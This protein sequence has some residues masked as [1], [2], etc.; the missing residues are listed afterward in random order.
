MAAK[1]IVQTLLLAFC[2]AACATRPMSD[3]GAFAQQSDS[4]SFEP[5]EGAVDAAAL[6][7]PVVHD[8]QLTGAAC[9][10]HA[11]A[12]VVNYWRGAGTVAGV[13]IFSASPP[14]D[15]ERGY[16][17]AEIAVLAGQR[18]LVASGVRLNLPDLIS[19]LESGR[20]VL[21]PVRIPSIYVQDRGLPRADARVVDLARG[22]VMDRVGRVSEMT[23]LALV[24]HYLL[25][26]GYD[27]DRFVVVEP[28]MGYRTISFERLA[29]YRR[30]FNDA[31]IV[32]SAASAPAQAQPRR[33]S[34][35]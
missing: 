30:A 5:F 33:G 35:R 2:L 18:G 10:A 19:E 15:L 25:L 14:A 11:L 8:R 7:L 17:I 12:S 20:P 16:S 3:V 21:V 32:F 26:V 27:R 28:V 22:V 29:R 6:V 13:D 1:P 9:G 31:A 34:R 4:N 24:D 23:N